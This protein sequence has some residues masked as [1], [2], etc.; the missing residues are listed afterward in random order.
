MR[1]RHR[2]TDPKLSLDAKCHGCEHGFARQVLRDHRPS[3][4]MWPTQWIPGKIDAARAK[5]AE[6]LELEVG[7][8]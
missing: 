7:N 1:R 2:E 5:F 4:G 8:L 6:L 3:D